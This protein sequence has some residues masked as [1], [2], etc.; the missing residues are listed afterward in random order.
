MQEI[1]FRIWLAGK[2]YYWG[3][4]DYKCGLIFAGLPSVNTDHVDMIE[5]QKRSQQFTGLRD[6]NGKEIYEGDIV[7][8]GFGPGGAAI[9]TVDNVNG[10]TV[11]R[12]LPGTLPEDWSHEYYPVF[13]TMDH[14]EVIGNIYENPEL[15][16]R[17]V[18][19]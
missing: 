19:G 7:K 6:K 3:F 11:V 17:E 1:K 4:I 8:E 2:F 15:L 14:S 18:E 10:D 5:A 13:G 16:K 9:G 12:F